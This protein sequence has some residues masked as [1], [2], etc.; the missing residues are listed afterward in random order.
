M[1]NPRT[2]PQ[3]TVPLGESAEP[4]AGE[5]TISRKQQDAYALASHRKAATAREQGLFH[6]ES[7]PV[8][9]PRGTGDP[10]A[11]S[12]DACVRPGTSLA[13]PARRGR[14]EGHRPRTARPDPGDQASARPTRTASTSP[15]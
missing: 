2:D 1:V 9:V 11:V 14:P 12:A 3:W 10:V 5:H 8:P 6:A 15:R 7:A 13:A 4:I